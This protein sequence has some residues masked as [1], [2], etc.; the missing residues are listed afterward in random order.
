[1]LSASVHSAVHGNARGVACEQDSFL[2]ARL[3]RIMGIILLAT[4]KEP[5][6]P[7][8]THGLK[9][10]VPSQP[11]PVRRGVFLP[12]KPH[13]LLWGLCTPLVHHPCA[14]CVPSMHPLYAHPCRRQT[15]YN[16]GDKLASQRLN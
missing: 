2:C 9:G 5:C 3:A 13:A 4:A 7:F 11:N 6:Q 12:C 14:L 15:I 16:D 8:E 10:P 1:M